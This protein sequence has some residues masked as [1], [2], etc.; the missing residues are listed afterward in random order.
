VAGEEPPRAG[1]WHRLFQGDN[2]SGTPSAKR[3]REDTSAPI[4]PP[5]ATPAPTSVSDA[6][7]ASPA[8]PASASVSPAASTSPSGAAP[9]E[10]VAGAKPGPPPALNRPRYA[11]TSPAKPPPGDRQGA[12]GEFTRARQAEQDENWPA[13]EQGYQKAADLDPSWFE[14]QYNAGIVAHQLRQYAAALPR[15]ELALAI[16]PDSADAR[17]NF[18]QALRAAGYVFDAADQLKKVLAAKP[19]EVRAHLALANLYAQ[20]L[21]D[22]ALAR[23]H[24]VRVL[25]LQPDNPHATDIRFWLAA[26][27]DS[28]KT[29]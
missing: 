11:Y 18:A 24:Y 5:E 14:A 21:H 7:S 29:P 1:F 23:L 26:N 20:S 3:F 27:S 17:Y 19:N 22:V 15:Y 28:K 2:P 6:H 8:S 16:Q 25:A 10:E 12:Q 13:A 4:P 9:N